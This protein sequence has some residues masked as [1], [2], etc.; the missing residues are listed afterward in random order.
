MRKI[1]ITGGA[2]F[3]GSSL[4]IALKEKYPADTILV[5]D[6]LKRRGSE[7]QVQR[8]KK[9]RIPFF[10][11]DVRCPEDFAQLPSVDV[12][13]DAAAEP[14]VMAGLAGGA[15]ALIAANLL[16]TINCLRFA[17]QHGAGFIFLSTSRVY[18]LQALNS[19]RFTKARSRF[20]LAARQALPGVSTRGVSETFPLSGSRSLYGATKLA[21]EL[22]ITE[23]QALLGLSAVINRCAVIAGPWQMGTAQQ[24]IVALWVARHFW[25][26]PTAYIGYGGTGKQVRDILHVDDLFS[27][28]DY[29]LQH[30]PRLS[31]ETFNIG[32]GRSN[33]ISLRE[34]TCLCEEVTGQTVPVR[35]VPD[36]RVADVPIYYTDT[37]KATTMMHWQPRIS[38]RRIVEDTYEWIRQ[39][40]SVLTDVLQ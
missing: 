9:Y 27:L 25:R 33:A 28:I 26:Q 38:A 6:N 14:S 39:N 16:G 8:F 31:G 22:L 11:G 7:L 34:L 21:A 18:P 37:A 5:L 35:R 24:G 17:H 29:Q 3:V 12:V 13:I 20:V 19:L 10:H 2:G 4:A 32:G 40:E 23:Y 36:T 15:D 1:A 30:L